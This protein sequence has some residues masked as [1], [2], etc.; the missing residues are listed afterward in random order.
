M[1]LKVRVLVVVARILNWS[2]IVISTVLSE[3]SHTRVGLST[4]YSSKTAMQV[5]VPWPPAST[6]IPWIGRTERVGVWRAA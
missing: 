2:P 6:D 5:M 3:N 4:R 1:R